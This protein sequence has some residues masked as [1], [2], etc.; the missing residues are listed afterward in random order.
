MPTLRRSWL[1]SGAK[2]MRV[3]RKQEVNELL[4]SKDDDG[5]FYDFT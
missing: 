3:K 1:D 4:T 2:K 5:I